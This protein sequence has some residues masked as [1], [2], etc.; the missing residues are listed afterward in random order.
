MAKKIKAFVDRIEG[1]IAVVY[2][3]KNEDVKIDIP[4]KFLPKELKEGTH[5]NIN[6][7]IDEK[8]NENNSSEIDDIRKKM[9][10][11]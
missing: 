4:L 2:L 6:I 8:E 10:S 11:N 3:G 7:E 9:M 1:K 5:L